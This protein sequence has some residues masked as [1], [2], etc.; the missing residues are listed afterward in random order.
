MIDPGELKPLL[1]TLVLPP[2]GPLLLALAGLWLM[3]RRRVAGAAVAT[4]ALLLTWLLSCHAVAIVLAQ[5]LLPQVA[6]LHPAA[7]KGGPVQAI[8]V[9]GGGVLPQAPE[10]GQAQLNG[11]STARLRYGLWLARQ[12][13]LPVAFAGGVGWAAAGMATQSEGAV[14][15]RTA[16]EAGLALRWVDEA[17]RDTAE[18]A[19]LT[20]ALLQ[21]DGMRHIALVTDAWHM[22]RSVQAFERAGLQVTPA[23]TGFALPL[24]RPLLEWLPSAHGLRLSRA[25]LREWLGLQVARLTG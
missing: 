2:A 21:K 6:P 15:R 9:L 11:P 23:P 18:N 20:A 10:Y 1:S 5:S 25:V 19:R 7:L 3:R 14:A 22:P 8:V 12:S 17:S 24:E 16:E 13:G 4:G